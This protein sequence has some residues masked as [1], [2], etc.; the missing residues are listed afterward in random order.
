M[1]MIGLSTLIPFANRQMA[2]QSAQLPRMTRL[3]QRFRNKRQSCVEFRIGNCFLDFLFLLRQKQNKK[4]K[5][6]AMALKRIQKVSSFSKKSTT[7]A[8]QGKKDRKRNFQ[9]GFL[10]G[11]PLGFM[12]ILAAIFDDLCCMYVYVCAYVCERE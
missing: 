9:V 1:L 11:G 8:I 12:F 3:E 4:H 5:K 10:K 2:L 7:R 6:K